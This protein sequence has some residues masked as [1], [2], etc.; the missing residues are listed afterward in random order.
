MHQSAILCSRGGLGG[1]LPVW[2]EGT[3]CGRVALGAVTPGR[4]RG[5]RRDE[6]L[7]SVFTWGK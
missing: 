5:A 6:A 3:D 2:G 4:V 7:M 1:V